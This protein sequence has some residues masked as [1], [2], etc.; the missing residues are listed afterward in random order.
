M[1][2]EKDRNILCLACGAL[3]R[4]PADKSLSGAKCGRCAAGLATPEPVDITSQQLADLQSKDTGAYLL[5][6]WAQWCGPCRM[7]APHY[8]A[9]AGRLNSDVRF[10]KLDSDQ[11]REAAARLQIRG[12]P[13]LFGWS[14]GRLIANQPGAQT[15]AGLETWIRKAFTLA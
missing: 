12:I 15:G 4:L 3:N 1:A 9:A 5:D 13:T 14:G 2:S 6:V 8:R 7:M 10:F 11:N